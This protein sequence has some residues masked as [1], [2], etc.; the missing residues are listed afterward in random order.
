M[1]RAVPAP[2]DGRPDPLA[3]VRRTPLSGNTTKDA[4]AAIAVRRRVLPDLA[5][6]EPTGFSSAI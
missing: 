4:S 1:D 5:P 3:A 2:R 6:V